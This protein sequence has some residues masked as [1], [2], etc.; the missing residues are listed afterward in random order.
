M[1]RFVCTG[2][3]CATLLCNFITDY[4]ITGIIATTLA[5]NLKTNSTNACFSSSCPQ[6]SFQ[7]APSGQHQ[8]LLPPLP[9]SLD[10]LLPPFA[11]HVPP[12][13]HWTRQRAKAHRSAWA[14]PNA[15]PPSTPTISPTRGETQ[16]W[17]I[18]DVVMAVPSKWNTHNTR[19]PT[20]P[21]NWCLCATVVVS[22]KWASMPRQ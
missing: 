14:A 8:T 9:S 4:R 22:L 13:P 10:F 21:Q 7:H 3:V 18:L 2:Y 6:P 12:P 15:S 19:T 20:T 17:P 16:T 11:S 5:P 1:Y